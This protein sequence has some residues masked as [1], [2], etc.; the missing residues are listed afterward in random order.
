MRGQ[1]TEV[2]AGHSATR[3]GSRDNDA[4]D[5]QVNPSGSSSMAVTTV[6]P[7]AKD[8]RTVRIS[9]EAKDR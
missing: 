8:P 2:R 9:R 6:T 1:V 5:W 4:N 3:G 7:E